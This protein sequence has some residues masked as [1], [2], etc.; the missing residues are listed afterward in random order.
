MFQR[1]LIPLDGSPRA[2]QAL[3]VAAR[4]ARA[5]GGSILLLRVVNISQDVLTYGIGIPL[6]TPGAI[7]EKL[8][9]AKN[10]LDGFCQRADLSGIPVQALALLGNPAMVIPSQAVEKSIDLIILSS[11]GYTGFKRWALGSIAQKIAHASSIPVLILREQRER[12]PGEHE[13]DRSIRILAALDGSP[14]AV[15]VLPYAAHLSMILSAPHAG[16]LRLARVIPFSLAFEYGQKDHFALERSQA[17]Q[18]AQAYLQRAE[19]RLRNDLPLHCSLRVRSSIASSLDTAQ[20]LLEL[21]EKGMCAGSGTLAD[22]SDI[23]ALTT[24]GHGGLT[25]WIMGSIA[26]RLLASTHLPLLVIHPLQ[27]TVLISQSKHQASSSEREIHT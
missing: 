6:I 21:A 2:E 14:L 11:H 24:R 7:E 26:E 25:H 23:I 17:I 3:P 15:T 27:T 12:S 10:Y 19:T 1:L 16:E 4:L 20:S 9:E 8:A 22:T 13:H 18:E 5:S